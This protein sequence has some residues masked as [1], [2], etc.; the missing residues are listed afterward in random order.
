MVART[1]S[2]PQS[3]D[4]HAVA[5][6][7]LAVALFGVAWAL[8]HVGFYTHKQVIDTP[9][10]QRYGN[11]IAHGHVPYRDFAVEY[12][13]GAL[14]VFALPGFAEP[15]EGQH[16]TSGFRTTFETLMWICGAAALLGMVLVLRATRAPPGRIWGA[17]TFAAVAPLAL[18]SVV[19]SRFDL[20]PAAVVVLALAALV[21]G[22]W[23][24]GSALIGL[25]IAIKL[26]PVVL[27]PLAV[28]CAWRRG[29]RR[30][31][32]LS[33]AWTLGVAAVV[34][35]PFVVVAPGGIWH[36]L[37][38]QLSRPLQI[39]SVGSALLLAVHHAFGAGLSVVTSHGSQNLSGGAPDALAVV[40]TVLQIA[41]LVWVWIAFARG[42]LGLLAAAAA[43][44]AGFIAFGKVLSPQFLIWLVAIVPLVSGRRGLYGMAL[45]AAA[46]VLTQLWFPFRYWD[47]ANDLDPTA[48]WLV[49]ARDLVLV[50]LAGVL[51]WPER[52]LAAAS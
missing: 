32:L 19:L 6:G 26:Y 28:V 5:A 45:L 49:V 38:G 30:A 9:I 46:L 27:L 13:P 52:R 25:G 1:E 33:L 24:L 4:P 10:Y 42:R 7:V 8:L 44:L 22:R 16:V 31:A 29:G 48:S 20:W 50:A 35:L 15:G 3:T 23:R 34:F 43:A 17:L 14:P 36:S 11:A 47:L 21:V 41:F 18:G 12:P 37:S 39:E 2:Y 40:V 51:A